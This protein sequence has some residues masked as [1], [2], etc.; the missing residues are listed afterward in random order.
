MA[1]QTF[2]LPE[3]FTLTDKQR[4]LAVK[5]LRDADNYESAAT[6]PVPPEYGEILAGYQ[7]DHEEGNRQYERELKNYNRR[8]EELGDELGPREKLARQIEQSST[9]TLSVDESRIIQNALVTLGHDEPRDWRNDPDFSS[10]NSEPEK[11]HALVRRSE[12]RNGLHANTEAVLSG[13]LHEMSQLQRIEEIGNV[14]R[15]NLIDDL[16]LRYIYIPDDDKLTQ[17]MDLNSTLRVQERAQME[18]LRHGRV[19]DV[20]DRA[21]VDDL[22]VEEATGELHAKANSIAQQFGYDSVKDLRAKQ[23]AQAGYFADGSVPEIHNRDQAFGGPI[24]YERRLKLL[25]EAQRAELFADGTIAFWDSDTPLTDDLSTQLRSESGLM[26]AMSYR[27]VVGERAQELFNANR[28]TQAQFD[29][30]GAVT[31]STV[32]AQHV[33]MKERLRTLGLPEEEEEYLAIA[34]LWGDGAPEWDQVFHAV[35]R[36]RSVPTVEKE[37]DRLH[38]TE[39]VTQLKEAGRI[40]ERTV[41]NFQDMAAESA[42]MTQFKSRMHYGGPRMLGA[43]EYR[44]LQSALDTPEGGTPYSWEESEAYVKAFGFDQYETVC[45]ISQMERDRQQMA[46]PSY[47]Q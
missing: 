18:Q 6:D 8:M 45:R 5:F 42:D 41:Q 9:H 15:G 36:N 26:K 22:S 21:I 4:L 38:F 33:Q 2:T 28:I 46:T 40:D 32:D 47:A 1:Q 11:L 14:Q 43:T 17:I 31:E 29:E 24:P 27:A 25:E 37:L 44:Y 16:S 13:L 20:L 3:V 30:L 19:S 35:K 10:G 7:H 23:T 12:Y 34:A 39:R